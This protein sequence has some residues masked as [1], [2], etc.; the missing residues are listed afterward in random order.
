MKSSFKYIAQNANSKIALP[1]QAQQVPSD[2]SGQSANPAVTGA[3]QQAQPQ[4]QPQQNATASEGAPEAP[5]KSKI[6][7]QVGLS[8]EMMSKVAKETM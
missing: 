1:P 4:Q 8:S 6:L 7:D 5:A 2:A 3:S